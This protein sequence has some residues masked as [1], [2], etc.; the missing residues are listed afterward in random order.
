MKN[1]NRRPRLHLEQLETRYAPAAVAVQYTDVDGDKVKITDSSGTL[2]MSN[3][4]LV[5]GQLRTLD[6]SA[7]GFKGASI[8]FSV[9]PVAGGDGLA[10]VGRIN[11]GTNDLGAVRV[12]G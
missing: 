9:T 10:A 8:S 12:K 4:T 1:A 6:L 3:L 7:P 11:A 5:G 2:Q